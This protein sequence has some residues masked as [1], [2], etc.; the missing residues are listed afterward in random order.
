MLKCTQNITAGRAPHFG[1]VSSMHSNGIREKQAS[2]KQQILRAARK[3]FAQHGYEATTTRMIAEKVGVSQS[4]ISFHFETKENLCKAAVEYT[5]RNIGA[6]LQPA[7]DA[8]DAAFEKG[9]VSPERAMELIAELL[10]RQIR[11]VFDPRSK[12][13]VSLALKDRAL[14]KIA[15][16]ILPEVLFDRVES[17]LARLILA[18]SVSSNRVWAEVVSRAANGAIFSF[19]LNPSLPREARAPCGDSPSGMLEEYLLDYLLTAIQN[20]ASPAE[21]TPAE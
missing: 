11:L 14:P 4:A 17:E 19:F 2:T 20:C 6:A 1:E 13:A 3:L 8:V 12:C 10:L 5:A 18:Y 9:P 16:G 15:Q 21:R 7:Y